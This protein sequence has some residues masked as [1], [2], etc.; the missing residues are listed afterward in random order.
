MT[1]APS[2]AQFA[3]SYA[4]AYVNQYMIN[5]PVAG[6]PAIDYRPA[7]GDFIITSDLVQAGDDIRVWLI[8]ENEIGRDIVTSDPEEVSE[9]LAEYLQDGISGAIWY[10]VLQVIADGIRSRQI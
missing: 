9:R 5:R 8:E 2:R 10:D 1:K 4:K 7:T 6:S 3:V